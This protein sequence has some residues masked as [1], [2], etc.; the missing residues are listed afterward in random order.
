ML[1]QRKHNRFGGGSGGRITTSYAQATMD[2]YGSRKFTQNLG[3]TNAAN[4]ATD[5]GP[6]G[7]H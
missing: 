1:S 4:A 7:W 6:W 5:F 2:W 3:T